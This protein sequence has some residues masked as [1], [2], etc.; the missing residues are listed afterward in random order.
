MGY[1]PEI[2]VVIPVFNGSMSLRETLNA[3]RTQKFANFEV[4][5][6]N[7][8]ST[9]DS[10]DILNAYAAADDRFRV[11]TTPRN[12]GSGSAVAKFGVNLIKGNYYAYASQDDLF[13][14]DWLSSLY[15]RAKATGADAVVAEMI[16]F[17]GKCP[18]KNTVWLGMENLKDE[19]IT[20]RQAFLY[21][22]NETI[23]NFALWKRWLIDKIGYYD[24]GMRADEY[25]YRV[26]FLNCGKVAFASG[27]FYYRSDNSEAITEKLTLKSFDTP[28]NTFRLWKLARDN[29]APHDVQEK[30]ILTSIDELLHFNELTYWTAFKA[31]KV[32]IAQCYSA[33][34]SENVS[35]VFNKRT[36]DNRRLLRARIVTHNNTLFR[37]VTLYR[38]LRRRLGGSLRSLARTVLPGSLR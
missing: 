13:S 22:L 14:D 20:G 11:Y 3:I 19:V 30:L 17:Y 9:D 6:A 1:L 36:L 38:V 28:Y 8:C 29:D 2:S 5:C 27:R 16:W 12:L 32:K 15:E 21:S 10:L 18:E 37:L 23:H 35:G 26:W 25:T 4:V 24:F 7:D 33:Y 31:G 34:L